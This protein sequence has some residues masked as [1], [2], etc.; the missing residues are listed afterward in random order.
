MTFS[1]HFLRK[2]DEKKKNNAELG[3]VMPFFRARNPVSQKPTDEV[4]SSTPHWPEHQ[5]NN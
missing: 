2:Q 3:P 4:D 1:L 5:H